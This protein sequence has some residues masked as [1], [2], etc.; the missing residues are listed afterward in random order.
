MPESQR[1]EE[2]WSPRFLKKW[3]EKQ[4]PYPVLFFEGY[5][6]RQFKIH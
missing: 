2:L 4:M 3:E 5:G 1:F 6:I